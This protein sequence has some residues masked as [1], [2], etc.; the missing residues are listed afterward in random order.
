MKI[1]RVG[2]PQPS[3]ILEVPALDGDFHGIIATRPCRFVYS[4]K[5]TCFNSTFGD[6]ILELGGRVRRRISIHEDRAEVLS[7]SGDNNF[8]F[9]VSRDVDLVWHRA[10]AGSGVASV[11]DDVGIHLTLPGIDREIHEVDAEVHPT[12]T[13]GLHISPIAERKTDD[14]ARVITAIGAVNIGT[15]AAAFI[16]FVEGKQ[17]GMPPVR[18][19]ADPDASLAAAANDHIGLRRMRAAGKFLD[20]GK[21]IVVRIPTSA[22]SGI[23]IIGSCSAHAVGSVI[24]R[25]ETVLIFPSVGQTIAIAVGLERV[26]FRPCFAGI[27]VSVAIRVAIHQPIEVFVFAKTILQSVAIRVGK[28]RACLD[29]RFKAVDQTIGPVAGI[30]SCRCVGGASGSE[31][32]GLAITIGPTVG[33]LVFEAVIESVTIGICLGRI[34]H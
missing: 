18:E 31:R 22:V 33:V 12:I 11:D 27:V 7:V 14:V 28:V 6:R 30:G 17:I 4:S 20:V 9:H 5:S 13:A 25:I 24:E 19:S 1:E 21:A 26:R 34:G 23:A 2:V 15:L 16:V 8:P 3:G 29:P 10:F 32:Q